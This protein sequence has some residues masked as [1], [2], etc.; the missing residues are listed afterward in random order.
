MKTRY[1]ELAVI[2]W[3]MWIRTQSPA[4]DDWSGITGFGSEQQCLKSMQEKIDTWKQ[5]KDAS[6]AKNVVTFSGNNTTMTYQCLP[7]TEDPRRKPPA[8]PAR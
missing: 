4:L 2:G 1:L 3:A 5:F 6:F 8:K 7:D